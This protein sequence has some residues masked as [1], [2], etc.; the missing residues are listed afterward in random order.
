MGR[1]ADAYLRGAQV[2]ALRDKRADIEA[3]KSRHGGKTMEELMF[4]MQKARQDHD[5][6]Q[7]RFQKGTNILQMNLPVLDKLMKSGSPEQVQNYVDGMQVDLQNQGMEGYGLGRLLKFYTIAG[8]QDRKHFNSIMKAVAQKA[9]EKDFNGVKAELLKGKGLVAD[10][11]FQEVIDGYL[12]NIEGR[13]ERAQ[14]LADFIYKERLKNQYSLEQIGA[15]GRMQKDLAGVK[16]GYEAGNIRLKAREAR[17]TVKYKKDI[18]AGTEKE[19]LKDKRKRQQLA[20]LAKR[21]FQAV[22]RADAAA[23]RVG[24]FSVRPNKENEAIVGKYRKMAENLKKAYVA[25]GGDL[26]NLGIRAPYPEGLTD[27]MME[28]YREMYPGKTDEEIIEAYKAAKS[29]KK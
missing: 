16:A 11:T 13:E 2:K 17:N 25:A 14:D 9:G 1:F 20:S 3:F 4:D 26:A 24:E 23:R 8:E 29:R 10:E 12:K 22:G 15:R 7:W 19:P 18:G 5:M 6:A 28:K 21:Y 27:D